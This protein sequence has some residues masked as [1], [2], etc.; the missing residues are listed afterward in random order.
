MFELLEENQAKPK[1]RRNVIFLT[2]IGTVLLVLGGWFAV[3]WYRS[4]PVEVDLQIHGNKNSRIYHLKHCPNYNDI[5]PHNLINF[6]T[7]EE[8]KAA[9][10]RM[11]RNCR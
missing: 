7:H 2:V 6:K 10:F 9:G 4:Q 11:A 8:A 3:S 5:S 1:I